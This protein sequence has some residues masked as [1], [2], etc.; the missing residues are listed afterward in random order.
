MICVGRELLRLAVF[1]GFDESVDGEAPIAVSIVVIDGH[2]PGEA[3]FYLSVGEIELID[4][5]TGIEPLEG[6]VPALEEQWNGVAV[7]GVDGVEVL[8][9]LGLGDE[10]VEFGK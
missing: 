4:A 2:E 9:G 1:Q 6:Q 5:K 3:L 7:V 10:A 8:G